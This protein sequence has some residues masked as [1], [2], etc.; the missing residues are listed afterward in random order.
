M[1]WWLKRLVRWDERS[2]YEKSVA[3]YRLRYRV[4]RAASPVGMGL[5]RLMRLAGTDKHHPERAGGHRYGPAYAEALR[6]FRWRAIRMLEIGIGGTGD[7]AGGRSLLAWL[8]Y[9]PRATV[10]ACDLQDR[11]ALGGGR[12]QIRQMNQGDPADLQRVAE[13][14]PFDVIV[15]DGSHLSAHQRMT[16]A[17]LFDALMEGGLYV[18]ED[19]QTSYWH[20]PVGGVVWDGAAP[21]SAGFGQTCVGWFLELAKHLNH[22]EFLDV[23]DPALL[24]YARQIRRITFEHNLI[25][26][27]KGH[28]DAVS[29]TVGAG[30]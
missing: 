17:A 15:D 10:I 25:L 7:E 24:A 22:A 30:A 13:E 23:A 1:K 16:F 2:D 12:L 28:N 20:R 29:N 21:Q 5:S 4:A 6:P 9:F 14:G 18:I 19:V 26:I 3:L 27:H 8:A 11:S